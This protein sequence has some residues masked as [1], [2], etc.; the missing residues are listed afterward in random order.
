VH[1][2]LR[3][4]NELGTITVMP[5]GTQRDMIFTMTALWAEAENS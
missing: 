5:S 2:Q 4:P 1:E 3:R